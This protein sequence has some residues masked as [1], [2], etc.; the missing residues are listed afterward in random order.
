MSIIFMVLDKVTSH[1]RFLGL[2]EFTLF[3]SVFIR[4]ALIY[5]KLR[6]LNI[7]LVKNLVVNLLQL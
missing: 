4:I 1:N 2:W 5:A 3:A 7:F 6:R